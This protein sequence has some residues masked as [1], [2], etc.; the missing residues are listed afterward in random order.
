MWI[1]RNYLRFTGVLQLTMI[2]LG[3][4]WGGAGSASPG[5]PPKE[6]PSSQATD[7]SHIS[8]PAAQSGALDPEGEGARVARTTGREV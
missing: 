3:C 7:P 6:P 8:H 4:S 2:S 5:A 1:M